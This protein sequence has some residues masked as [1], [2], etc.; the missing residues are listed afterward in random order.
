MYTQKETDAAKH[1]VRATYDESYEGHHEHND[2]GILLAEYWLSHQNQ[3][4]HPNKRNPIDKHII[5]S[6]AGVYVSSD[7]VAVAAI[8]LDLKGTYPVFNISS[9]LI[10]PDREMIYDLPLDYS[11]KQRS[12]ERNDFKYLYAGV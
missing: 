9:K 7:D 10:W 6:W 8:L 3:L 2:S 12:L 4:M 1:E 11:P 5:E